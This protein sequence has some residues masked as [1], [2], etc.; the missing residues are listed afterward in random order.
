MSDPLDLEG[1]EKREKTEKELETIRRFHEA[2][3][4][5]WIMQD[6]RGRRFIW[7]ILERGGLFSQAFDGTAEGT[8]FS[9]GAKNEA[10]LVMGLIFAHCPEAFT[11]MILERENDNGK[12]N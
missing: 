5:K 3:D 1:Q 2:D 4:F 9:D 6:K 11:A 12:P 10:R 8:I 7:S